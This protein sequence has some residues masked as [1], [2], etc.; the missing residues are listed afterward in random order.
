MTQ[1]ILISIGAGLLSALLFASILTGS[2]VSLVLQIIAQLPLQTTSLTFGPRASVIAGVAAIAALLIISGQPGQ[3]LSFALNFATPALIASYLAG[4]KD[5]DLPDND[6][7]AWYP[8]GRILTI[9]AGAA[10]IVFVVLSFYSGFQPEQAVAAIES[11]ALILFDPA[12]DSGQITPEAINRLAIFFVALFPFV[13]TAGFVIVTT[14]NL[15]LAIRIAR[16]YGTFARP[17]TS[18]R[19]LDIPRTVHIVALASLIIIWTSGA[20][21]PFLTAI[22]GASSTLVVFSG[23]AA[24]HAL[25]SQLSARRIILFAT[26]GSIILFTIPLLL[27]LILGWIDGFLNLRGRSNDRAPN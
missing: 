1:I 11:Q 14:L 19:F 25:T 20:S 21:H 18:I 12:V 26:Y 4:L 15:V 24:L 3:T 13:A 22:A 16:R 7:A 23:F 9:I 2:L 5:S 8:I 6:I 17:T 27:I 10:F